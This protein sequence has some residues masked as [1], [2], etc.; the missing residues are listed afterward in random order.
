MRGAGDLNERASRTASD[1]TLAGAFFAFGMIAATWRGGWVA[2]ACQVITL[3]GEAMIKCQKRLRLHIR[4]LVAVRVTTII[5][6]QLVC[7]N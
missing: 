2:H 4:S 3:E 1:S 7:C 5:D 6:C